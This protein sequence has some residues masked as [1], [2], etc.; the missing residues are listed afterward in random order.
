MPTQ[1]KYQITLQIPQLSCCGIKLLQDTKYTYI[2]IVMWDTES[3]TC[4]AVTC[5]HTYTH[6]WK[7]AQMPKLPPLK[8]KYHWACLYTIWN[9][10]TA[11]PVKFMIGSGVLPRPCIIYDCIMNECSLFTDDHTWVYYYYWLYLISV[12]KVLCVFIDHA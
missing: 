4:R 2:C 3:Y 10:Q 6:T 7:W 8:S 1:T 12:Y 9:T 5:L 11:V